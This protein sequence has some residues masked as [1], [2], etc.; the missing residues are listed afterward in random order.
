MKGKPKIGKEGGQDNKPFTTHQ[1][2]DGTGFA[3]VETCKVPSCDAAA[4]KFAD[5]RREDDRDG[6]RPCYSWNS[7]LEEKSYRNG[8]RTVIQQAKIS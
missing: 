4:C 1:G 2:P 8:R 7:E 3:P 5:E 6:V